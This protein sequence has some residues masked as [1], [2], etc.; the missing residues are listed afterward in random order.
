MNIS[1]RFIGN[2]SR[3]KK[4][5]VDGNVIIIYERYFLYSFY[6]FKVF[7]IFNY[8]SYFIFN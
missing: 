6:I 2:I 5:N 8:W 1:V 7:R 3:F 4:R